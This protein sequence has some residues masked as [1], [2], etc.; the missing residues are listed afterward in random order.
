MGKLT[1]LQ[2]MVDDW[3]KE[4]TDKVVIDKLTSIKTVV[5]DAEQEQTALETEKKELLTS[6]KEVI[7]HTSFKGKEPE[8]EIGA[9]QKVSIDDCIAQTIKEFKKEK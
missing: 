8:D 6:Y 4:A 9:K 5:N 2:K 1:E 7:K 3:F